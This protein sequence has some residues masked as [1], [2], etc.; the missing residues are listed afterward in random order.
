MKKALATVGLLVLSFIPAPSF[1]HGNEK[2]SACELSRI[3]SGRYGGKAENA[4]FYCWN[5]N[6]PDVGIGIGIPQGIHPEEGIP[7]MEPMEMPSMEPTEMPSIEPMEMPD[8]DL[9]L[10]AD[11]SP[12]GSTCTPGTPQFCDF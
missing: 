10:P 12:A 6:D 4:I 1:S 11:M 8:I 2:Y 5:P 3:V 9:M 7:D